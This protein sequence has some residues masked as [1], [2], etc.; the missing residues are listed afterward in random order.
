MVESK[1]LNKSPFLIYKQQSSHNIQVVR[2]ASY[3]VL[4]RE[5]YIEQKSSRFLLGIVLAQN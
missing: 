5:Y 4:V 1:R 2:I 3:G